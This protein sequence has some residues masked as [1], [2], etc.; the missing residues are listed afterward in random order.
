MSAA[1]I[2]NELF[3]LQ[4]LE[5]SHAAGGRGG[6]F[7]ERRVVKVMLF[8]SSGGSWEK[9]YETEDEA[10]VSE[11]EIPYYVARI[12]IRLADGTEAMG[13]GVVEPELVQKMSSKTG[14]PFPP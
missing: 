6:G 12:P 2:D 10:K 1:Q 14:R 9:L 4:M 8:R 7:G 11:F 13:Y 3:I 5:G